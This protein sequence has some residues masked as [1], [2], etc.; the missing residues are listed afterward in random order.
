[1]DFLRSVKDDFLT[2]KLTMSVQ[3]TEFNPKLTTFF[4]SK[5]FVFPEKK[6]EVF[7]QQKTL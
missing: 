3:K 2:Q 4:S 6:S 1:M 5:D 7:G